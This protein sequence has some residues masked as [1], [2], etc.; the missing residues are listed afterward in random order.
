MKRENSQ[1][2]IIAVV[3]ALLLFSLAACAGTQTSPSA[4]DEYKAGLSLFNRGKF[5]EA[6]PRFEKAT[7]INPEFGKAYL[8]LGRT[9]LNLG[10]WQEA[11]PPLRAAMRYSPG[12]TKK[13]AADLVLDILLKYAGEIDVQTRKQLE[14]IVGR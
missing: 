13:E 2:I 8:Y 7:E 6:V 11:V 9:L 4:E 5:D 3:T 1:S 12:E 14:G 10:R